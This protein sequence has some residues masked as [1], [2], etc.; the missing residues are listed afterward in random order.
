MEFFKASSRHG[1]NKH[2]TYSMIVHLTWYKLFSIIL[3]SFLTNVPHIWSYIL[4]T[5]PIMHL[6]GS[7]SL[8][9][10]CKN[11][12]QLIRRSRILAPYTGA[13]WNMCIWSNFRN[14]QHMHRLQLIVAKTTFLISDYHFKSH[15]K[16]LW[17]HL[18][19]SFINILSL[20]INWENVFRCTNILNIVNTHLIKHK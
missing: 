2:P 10:D 17:H 15:K 7:I 9:I 13:L 8:C 20:Y 5:Y 3:P 18:Y 19:S 4:G 14:I 11:I 6:G 16:F 12:M 1:K